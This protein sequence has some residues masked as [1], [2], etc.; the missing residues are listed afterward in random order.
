M[1]DES[2]HESN[3][4]FEKNLEDEV[5]RASK[6]ASN[7]KA[8]ATELGKVF[9]NQFTAKGGL[10]SYPTMQQFESYYQRDRK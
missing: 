1:A 2:S 8:I 3:D 9:T 7:A 5:A 6:D 4:E 10:I